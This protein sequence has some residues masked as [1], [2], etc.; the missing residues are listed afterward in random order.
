MVRQPETVVHTCST[1]SVNQTAALD[2]Q[3]KVRKRRDKKEEYAPATWAAASKLLSGKSSLVKPW[4]E[5][6]GVTFK[7]SVSRLMMV[8]E[9]RRLFW[10]V[11][12]VSWSLSGELS[13]TTEARETIPETKSGRRE[14]TSTKCRADSY[15][16][17]MRILS[18]HKTLG[19]VQRFIEWLKSA[20]K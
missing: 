5:G 19:D 2:K 10:S 9:T 11:M 6:G 8:R 4:G 1:A 13:E 20:L 12:R 14:I 18:N 16:I 17:W 15:E 7:P 3:Q